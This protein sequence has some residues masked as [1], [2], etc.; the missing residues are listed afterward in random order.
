MSITSREISPAACE[1]YRYLLSRGY[2]D[3]A[4][5]K[6]V[7]D[8][9]RLSRLERNCLFRGTVSSEVAG[10]RRRK[11][12]HPE[13]VRGGRLGIDWYNVLITV[14]TYLKGGVLFLADDGV[15]RDAAAVHGSWRKSAVTDAAVDALVITLVRIGPSRMD[16]F[17]DAPVAFSG[18]LAAELRVRMGEGLP[19]ASCEVVLAASA[20]WPLKRYAGVVASSDSVVLDSA[21][22]VLDL[23]RQAL[24]WR[25]GF[26]P[27]P[28]GVR[29]SP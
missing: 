24:E 10:A 20:D 1:E 22:K 21:A 5:L 27:E 9:H 4:A 28:I 14:E 16:V 17:L 25:Y 18:E 19:G 13:E 3:T 23:P 2:S 6:L 15:T 12:V 7:G 26:T 29:K 8:R 11:I